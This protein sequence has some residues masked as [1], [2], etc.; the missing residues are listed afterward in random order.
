MPERVLGMCAAVCTSR[1]M[2]SWKMVRL[3]HGGGGGGDA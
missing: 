1:R 2:T 3:C